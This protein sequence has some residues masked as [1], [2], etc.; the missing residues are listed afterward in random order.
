MNGVVYAVRPASRTGN[1]A[2]AAS[3]IGDSILKWRCLPVSTSWAAIASPQIEDDIV[4]LESTDDSLSGLR[5][6]LS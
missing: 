2:R 6:L 1:P 5:V 4:R 3:V